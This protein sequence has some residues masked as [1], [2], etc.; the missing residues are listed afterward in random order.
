MAALFLELELLINLSTPE[1]AEE[2]KKQLKKLT[3]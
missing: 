3:K 2:I 1:T